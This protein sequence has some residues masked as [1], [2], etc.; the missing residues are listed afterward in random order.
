M[1]KELSAA[2]EINL[3]GLGQG[4]VVELQSQTFLFGTK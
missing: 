2:C 3:F 1:F 4:R